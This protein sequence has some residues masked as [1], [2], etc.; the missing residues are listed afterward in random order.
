MYDPAGALTPAPQLYF[1]S[2]LP[3]AASKALNQPLASPLKT[4]SPAVAR[5]PPISG[6]GVLTLHATLPVSR[7]TATSLPHCSSLG[8][9]LNA[10]PSHSLPPG[11]R[12]FLDVIR[13]RL[14]Q[15]RRIGQGQL[16]IHPHRRPFDAPIPP[17]PHPRP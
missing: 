6:C 3:L 4:R 16:G 12:H 17:L 8:M 2:S 9:V 10:P 13:H 5:T 14:V 7:L 15:I 11:V 1:H